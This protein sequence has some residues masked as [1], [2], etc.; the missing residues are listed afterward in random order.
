MKHLSKL[1]LTTALLL[2][3]SSTFAQKFGYINSTD[4]ITSMPEYKDAMQKLKDYEAEL[5]AQ[6]EAITVEFNTKFADYQKNSSTYTDVVRT[7]KES[8]LTNINERYE[9]NRVKM[10]QD[11]Q[12]MQMQLMDPVLTKARNAVNEI[13]KA[14]GFTIV[15]DTT[16]EAMIYYDSNT[17]TNVLPLV[18]TKLGIKE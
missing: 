12:A 3:C 17:M 16:V 7:A 6:L 5:S 10:G 18:K 8:E 2:I 14:N 4:L 9:Q 13:G 11:M 15:F 1:I